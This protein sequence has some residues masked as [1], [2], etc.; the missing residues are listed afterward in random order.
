MRMCHLQRCANSGTEYCGHYSVLSSP[1]LYR[2]EIF[3]MED[4]ALSIIFRMR[5]QSI[6]VY[7]FVEIYSIEYYDFVEICALLI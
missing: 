7:D 5:L 6:E 3:Y 1:K 2:K 4:V